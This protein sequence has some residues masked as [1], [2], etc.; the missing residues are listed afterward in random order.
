MPYSFPCAAKSL[1]QNDTKEIFGYNPPQFFVWEHSSNRTV[2]L[3]LSWQDLTEWNM[4]ED[5][6]ALLWSRRT[7]T[8]PVSLPRPHL[9]CPIRWPTLRHMQIDWQ[10]ALFRV[11]I[12][13]R[14][15]FIWAA[16][17]YSE[18][19]NLHRK[20]DPTHR[21]NAVWSEDV[22]HETQQK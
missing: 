12:K 3:S 13:G 17:K 6:H 7:H 10:A 2:H 1:I 18:T 16:K 21:G 8:F 15:T 14:P 9:L 19:L 5:S 20:C 11:G 22:W 4:C